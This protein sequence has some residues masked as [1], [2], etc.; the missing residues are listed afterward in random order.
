MRTGRT[1]VLF[2]LIAC[3]ILA[4][5]GDT[6][7]A[8]KITTYSSPPVAIGARSMAFADGMVSD[9]YDVS[10]MYVNAAALAYIQSSAVLYSHSEERFV[11]AIHENISI[12]L[13]LGA[14]QT[15]SF[16]ISA[17]HVGYVGQSKNDEF[18][19]FE[20]GYDMAFGVEIFREMSI[21]GTLNVRYGKSDASNLWAVSGLLGIVYAPSLNTS[22]GVA[23]KGIGNGI[24][25]S[26][27]QVSTS[28]SSEKLPGSVE[29]GIT[30]R[31]PTIFRPISFTTSISNEKV[32]RQ[33]GI[34]YRC[35]AEILFNG[36]LFMRAG[37]VYDSG[38]LVGSARYGAGLRVDRFSCDYTYSPHEWSEEFY[39]LTIAFGVR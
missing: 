3:A 27:D 2:I 24:I 28:L 33:H 23:V 14:H 7:F 36:L 1:S 15:M 20:Y 17:Q 6:S 11:H 29:A 26:S 5:A 18:K 13:S 25:Y 12:P 39:R 32:F 38:S 37:Y 19:V 31:Y 22:Y 4:G 9:I 30:L 10:S 34:E 35:G 8:Q 21:G 16:G